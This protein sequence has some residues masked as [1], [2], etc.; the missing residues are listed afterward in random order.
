[1]EYERS[2]IGRPSRQVCSTGR[3]S[4]SYREG[5]DFYPLMRLFFFHPFAKG[6]KIEG[7]RG[8]IAMVW[9]RTCGQSFCKCTKFQFLILNQEIKLHR[10]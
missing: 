9:D 10:D 5:L 7:K 8:K 1:M 4:C 6:G 2:L 3:A